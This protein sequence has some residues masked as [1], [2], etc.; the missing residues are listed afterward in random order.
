MRERIIG[1]A[2]W[3]EAGGDKSVRRLLK[4]RDVPS[5][6]PTKQRMLLM[7]EDAGRALQGAAIIDQ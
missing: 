1:S 3:S 5:P 2:L 7:P 6:S 4:R